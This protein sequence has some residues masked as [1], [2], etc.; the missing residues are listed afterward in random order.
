MLSLFERY[1]IIMKR[2]LRLISLVLILIFILSAC[3]TAEPEIVPEY[4]VNVEGQ[5]LDGFKVVWGFAKS[6]ADDENVFGYIPGTA[7]AD[8]ALERM[9]SI[10]KDFNCVIE[11]DYGNFGSIQNNMQSSIVSGAQLYDI[12]TNESFVLVDSVRAG[13]LTGLSSYI[14]VANTDKWGTPN[15]LQSLIWHDDLYGVVPFAWP[16][17]LYTSFG[18]PI[19]VNESIIAKLGQEDPREFVENGT[20]NWDKF[21]ECLAIYTHD[22]GGRTIYGLATH[23]AYFAMMMFLSNGNTL[24]ALENG[25]VVCGAY[26]DSGFVALERAQKIFQDTCKDYIHPQDAHGGVG[27]NF[28]LNGDIVMLTTYGSELLGTESSIMY[29]ADNIGLLPYPQGP[30]AVPGLYPSY[31]E[32]VLYSTAIPINAKDVAA[33]AIVLDAMF[34][35]FEGFETKEDII[36]YMADQVFFDERDARVFVNML[37]H[38]EYGFF[39]EGARGVIQSSV[40]S[41]TTVATLL[42]SNENIYEKIVSDYMIN[43]YNGRVAVY[44]E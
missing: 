36:R 12:S 34:E 44:G 41:N 24:S 28:F 30:N 31:H 22:D 11:M 9:N 2:S 7:L 33:T 6:G 18:Y 23:D 39:K 26:T 42:E 37:E 20:W 38:T 5:D 8:L 15:M 25:E 16:E 3:Q 27:L 17:L 14:D 10:Q 13:Y 1:F 29:Q 35:P 40:E 43:H 32:S 19:V 4:S 21:E